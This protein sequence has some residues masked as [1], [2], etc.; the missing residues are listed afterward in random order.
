MRWRCGLTG[1]IVAGNG[2][3]FIMSAVVIAPFIMTTIAKLRLRALAFYVI[4]PDLSA[5]FAVLVAERTTVASTAL[6]TFTQVYSA[7]A[8]LYHCV[9]PFCMNTCWWDM[10]SWV[11]CVF[12]FSR[13][14]FAGLSSNCY[15]RC[16]CT[17]TYHT[18]RNDSS[19]RKRVK[20]CEIWPRFSTTVDFYG[21]RI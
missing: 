8:A 3:V 18:C 14:D 6:C 19:A 16:G 11:V 1:I 13:S 20:K 4:E 9:E 5:A 2:D 7:T 17:L 15:W 12:L 10:I 21:A